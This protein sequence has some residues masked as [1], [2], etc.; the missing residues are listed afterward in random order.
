MLDLHS[1]CSWW[2][3]F[4][5]DLS[6]MDCVKR[7]VHYS[8][9]I[10]SLHWPHHLHLQLPTP[11][12]AHKIPLLLPSGVRAASGSSLSSLLCNC[13]GSQAV[14][15]MGRRLP[16]KEITGYSH[17]WYTPETQLDP[18]TSDSDLFPVRSIFLKLDKSINQG[19]EG[20]I[21][22]HSNIIS[23]INLKCSS[24]M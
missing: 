19:K 11:I 9:P 15:H 20:V 10:S 5:K 13:L 24:Y 14:S 22:A 21:L 2:F 4:E 1:S 17:I 18:V 7:E 12:L 3:T 6:S 23:R 16:V 8:K